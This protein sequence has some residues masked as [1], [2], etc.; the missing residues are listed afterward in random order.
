MTTVSDFYKDAEKEWNRLDLPLCRIEFASTLNL[1]DRYFC[2]GGSIADIGGGPGRYALELLKRGYRVTLLDVSPENIAMAA[3]KVADAGL[4]PEA[5]LV[6]DARDLSQLSSQRFDGMLALGP[7]YHLTKKPERLA[8]LNAAKSLMKPNGILIAAYLNPWGIA[9]SLLSDAPGWFCD[10]GNF[11]SL[12]TGAE[13]TGARACSG[14]T[15]CC[16]ITPDEAS[17]EIRNAGFELLD[18]VGAEGF[19]GGLRREVEALALE[20]PAAFTKVIA[21]GVRTS[22]LPQYRRATDHLLLVGQVTA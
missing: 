20:N 8:F 15:E 14:F 17:D 1:I 11:V 18:E 3:A 16:W 6:G 22:T 19:A 7:P 4:K 12:V 10:E 2:K 9:R 13:F 5:L 21:F